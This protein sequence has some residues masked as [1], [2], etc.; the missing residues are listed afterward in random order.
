MAQHT[1]RHVQCHAEQRWSWGPVLSSPDPQPQHAPRLLRACQL[2]AVR[3]GAQ[4]ARLGSHGEPQKQEQKPRDQP[5][6]PSPAQP[7]PAHPSPALLQIHAAAVTKPNE[8][9]I[10]SNQILVITRG[11]D[12]RARSQPGGGAQISQPQPGPGAV[13]SAE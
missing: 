7:S 3:G 2:C 12:T 4:L 8:S 11:P 10:C 13:Q 6:Q 1:N 5:S 9:I